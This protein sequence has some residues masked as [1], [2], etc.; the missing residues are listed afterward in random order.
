MSRRREIE[1]VFAAERDRFAFRA[2]AGAESPEEVSAQ[3]QDPHK[4]GDPDVVG[5]DAAFVGEEAPGGGQPSP[6]QDA[7]DAAA[8]ALGLGYAPGEPINWEKFQ[9]RDLRREREIEPSVD[10]D[11]ERGH[12]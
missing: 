8:D 3:R 11:P 12:D 7:A 9:H 6:D 10:E 5:E 2:E 4:G 1:N